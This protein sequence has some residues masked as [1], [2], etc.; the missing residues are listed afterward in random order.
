MCVMPCIYT[1]ECMDCRLSD[2]LSTHS[3][4]V[5]HES[6]ITKYCKPCSSLRLVELTHFLY[7]PQRS[8]RQFP[9]KGVLVS[10]ILN[11]ISF[12]N[13]A[14]VQCSAA[15]TGCIFPPSSPLVPESAVGKR[16]K[17]APKDACVFCVRAFSV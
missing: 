14:S 10:G 16:L 7:R 6:E 17:V 15:V 3:Y 5:T 1:S 12:T 8:S 9:V 13:C 4:P 2:R 11:T